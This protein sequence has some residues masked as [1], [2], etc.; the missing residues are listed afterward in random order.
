M[1]LLYVTIL[2]ATL[3]C[4]AGL[5]KG[6]TLARENAGLT[7]RSDLQA[8]T[9]NIYVA[10]DSGQDIYVM[11]TLNPDWAL[12]DFIV[13]IGLLVVSLGRIQAAFAAAAG[14][15]IN[16]PRDLFAAI[17]LAGQIIRGAASVGSHTVDAAQSL[18]DAFKNTSTLIVYKDYKDVYQEGFLQ[19]YLSPDGIAGMLGAQTVTLMIMSG[20]GQQVAMW[21]TGPDNSWIATNNQQI[22]RSIYGTLWQQDPGAGT[23]NWPVASST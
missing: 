13:D 6:A 9:Q 4:I 11:A 14:L 19:Q 21:N 1:K 7:T 2:F 22:V 3:A 5:N 17:Q 23:E 18:V 8:R 20:D 15:T 16:T 12:A 10:N